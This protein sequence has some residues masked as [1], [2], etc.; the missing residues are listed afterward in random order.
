MKR[1]I[2][3]QWHREKEEKKRRGTRKRKKERKEKE[4]E[5][6]WPV[7]SV[8]GRFFSRLKFLPGVSLCGENSLWKDTLVPPLKR[9]R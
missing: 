7:V 3:K 2:K 8:D 4:R 6:G 5:Q 1:E 9:R